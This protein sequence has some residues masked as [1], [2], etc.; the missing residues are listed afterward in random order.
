[1]APVIADQAFNVSEDITPADAIGTVTATDAD[2]D[3]LSF[4]IKANDGDLFAITSA[5]ALTLAQGKS[6]DFAAKA[7][8][9]ITVEA[10]DGEKA[11]TAKVTVNVSPTGTDPDNTA[12]EIADQEFSAKEDIADTAVIGTV[13][14]SDADGDEI[15][16]AIT[17]DADGLFEVDAATGELSLMEGKALDF[18]AKAEHSITVEA[19]DGDKSATATVAIKVTNVVEGLAEDPASFVTTWKTEADNEEVVIWT[20]QQLTYD[21]TIDWGDGTEEQIATGGELIHIY[22]VPGTHTVAIKGKFPAIYNYVE[23]F[24]PS[25]HKLLSI[26][27]WGSIQWEDM[28]GAFGYCVNMVLNATDV[29]DLSQVTDMRVMFYKATSFHGDISGWDTSNVTNMRDMFHEAASFNGDLSGWDT[30]NV[31]NMAYMFRGATSFNG[32][33]SGWDTSNVVNMNRM[34]LGATAFDKDLG[35]WDISSVKYMEQMLDNSGMSALNFSNTLI[36][37]ANLEVQPNVSLGAAGVNICE[38]GGGF[39]AYAA[40]SGAPNNWTITFG[41]SEVCD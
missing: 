13:E 36:G 6:L 15:S 34:F 29:P 12:P 32:D 4:A 23:G 3:K 14:A 37:W 26:E 21:Y 8:H 24:N 20:D 2:G 9:T 40:L 39:A 33:I 41:S 17:A 35:N 18:E 11:A 5:G 25:A 19:R 38:N 22:A 7:Q 27:Q 1:T 10:S 28:F 31:T 30:A 16:F